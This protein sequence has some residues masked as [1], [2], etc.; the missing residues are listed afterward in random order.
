MCLQTPV[1][2]F[3]AKCNLSLT[4]FQ[5]PVLEVVSYCARN[6]KASL[7]RYE[8][9]YIQ[10]RNTDAIT[11]SS[12]RRK[13]QYFVAMGSFIKAEDRTYVQGAGKLESGET[14][15]S[16]HTHIHRGALK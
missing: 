8:S 13:V 4:L 10:Y 7:G 15:T 2:F 11:L 3:T 5:R 6:I 14:H 1:L 16:T 12:I 9:N